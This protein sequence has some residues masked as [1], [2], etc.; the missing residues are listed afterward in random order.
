MI[1]LIFLGKNQFPI[2]FLKS[3]VKLWPNFVQFIDF[4]FKLSILQ[5]KLQIEHE[6]ELFAERIM[7]GGFVAMC[8]QTGIFGRLT[9]WDYSWDIMWEIWE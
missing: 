2:F 8:V 4:F 7:W 5:V 3:Q 6:C 1:N 9:F